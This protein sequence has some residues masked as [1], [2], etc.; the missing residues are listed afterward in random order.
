MKS[1]VIIYNIF[2]LNIICL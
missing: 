2:I 1:I